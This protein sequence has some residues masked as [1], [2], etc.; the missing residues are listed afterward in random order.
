[1]QC[2]G[3]LVEMPDAAQL[4]PGGFN[5]AGKA[6]SKLFAPAANRFVADHDAA[7]EQQFFDVA[8]AELEAE[9]PAHGLA[10]NGCSKPVPTVERCR[11]H[12]VILRERDN[13]LVTGKGI[14]SVAPTMLVATLVER[15]SRFT[16]IVQVKG[17]DTVSVVA[18]LKRG[19]KPQH[20]HRSLTRVTVLNVKM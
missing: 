13:V 19:V 15:R 17:K 12:S 6:R 18:G 4:A 7:H 8:Q 14:S 20:L 5:A 10:D 1:M 2:L 16:I 9:V 11:L 3:H